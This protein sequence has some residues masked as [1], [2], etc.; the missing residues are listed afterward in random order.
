M[1]EHNRGD[2]EHGSLGGDKGSCRDEKSHEV[3]RTKKLREWDI[4]RVRGHEEEKE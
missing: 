4:G 2:T 1:H 3:L